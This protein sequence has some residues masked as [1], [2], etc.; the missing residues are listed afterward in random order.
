MCMASSTARLLVAP[1]VQRVCKNECATGRNGDTI[2]GGMTGP[3][4]VGHRG[5]KTP[6]VMMLGR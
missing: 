6:N 1:G 4:R 2:Q 3:P 5:S